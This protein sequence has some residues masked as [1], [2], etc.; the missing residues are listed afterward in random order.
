MCASQ[1]QIEKE[2]LQKLC[3]ELQKTEFWNRCGWYE[4]LYNEFRC[5]TSFVVD[6]SA[7]L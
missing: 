4:K 5:I 2:Y 3:G 7:Y 1:K 6:K